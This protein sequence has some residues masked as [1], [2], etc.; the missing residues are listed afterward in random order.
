MKLDHSSN[1]PLHKQAEDLLRTMIHQE[2]YKS[3]KL[4]PNEV[5]L[6]KSLNIS[7]NTLR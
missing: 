2:E 5:E 3:G 4:L 1:I 7:R 6:S